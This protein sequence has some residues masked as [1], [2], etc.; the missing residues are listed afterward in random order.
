MNSPKLFIT[1][2]EATMFS[3]KREE[4]SLPFS[5]RIKL[6]IHLLICEFCRLF[7]RQHKFISLQIKNLHTHEELTD[8]EK[9][10]MQHLIESA[11]NKS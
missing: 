9:D 1:C 2:S 3:I 4:R 11:T 8:L 5:E 7:D 6:F 10:K